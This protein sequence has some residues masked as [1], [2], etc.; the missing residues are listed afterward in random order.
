MNINAWKTNFIGINK[1]S[2]V[3]SGTADSFV[4]LNL[5]PYANGADDPYWSGGINPQ[6]YRWRVTFT[7]NERLHGSHL[8]RT[9]FRFNAQDIEVGDFVAG[10]QDGKVCQIMSIISKNDTELTAIV[11]DRLRY[12]TFRDPT[13]FGLFGTPGTVIFFQINELGYPMLDPVPG[14]A[15]SDFADNVLSRFQYLNP[16]INYLLEKE[17][18]GFEQGDAI[19]IDNE[20]FVLSNIDNV[21]KFLGTVVHPGPGPHQFILRPANGIIDFVPNMPGL[22]GDYIYP[23]IDGTGDL[24]TNDASRRP[25]YM[26][27]SHAIPSTTTGT[28]IDPVAQEGEVIEFNRRQLTLTGTNGST[29]S[30]DQVI[31]IINADTYYHKITAVAVGAATVATSDIATI[32]S[33]YGIVAGYSPFS[34]AINGVTV[35][36]TTTTSGSVA[37]GDATIADVNDMVLDINNAAIPNIEASVQDGASLV[38]KNTAGTAITITNISADAN[39]NNFAG[40]GS[41][42]S[43]PL[44]TPAETTSF[45]LR[46]ERPDGGPITIRDVQGTF[47]DRAGVMSG[48]TGRFAL[49]LNIEQGLRSS[50]VSVVADIMARD[51]LYPLVGDQAHVLDAGHGEWAIFIYNGSEWEEFGN[52]RSKETDAKTASLEIDLSVIPSGILPLTRITAGRKVID[53]TVEVDGSTDSNNTVTV[54]VAGNLSLLA[55]VLDSNLAKDGRYSTTTNYVTT[56]FTQ[57]LVNLSV[58]DP[59]GT[60]TIRLSYV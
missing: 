36:F 21:G 7:V 16:L 54:G 29:V 11:E 6:Y 46:L 5:W 34:A 15:A 2:K 3:L 35:N 31:D 26:K 19:C 18:N 49:G 60:V 9:P 52:K 13:G 55:D 32:G 28:G 58:A 12:N 20:E 41:V 14:E 50:K 47:L 38:I 25:I 40:P 22:V 23:S 53:V 42:S 51:A 48:Q 56:D 45:A 30:L 8:T 39:G 17:N 10:A 37:Y 44:F 27:V 1:P 57:I 43:L 33:A 4:S 24:T 59:V